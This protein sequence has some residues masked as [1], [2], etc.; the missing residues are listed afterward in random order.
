MRVFP[1]TVADLSDVPGKTLRQ[2]L[3]IALACRDVVLVGTIKRER[4]TP[5]VP[6]HAG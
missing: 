4:V 6:G 3:N 1:T 2:Q 5:L